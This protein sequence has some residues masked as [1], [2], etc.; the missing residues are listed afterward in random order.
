MG[1]LPWSFGFAIIVSILGWLQFRSMFDQTVVLQAAFESC[2]TR[3]YDMMHDIEQ[4]A[5]STY[6]E[7]VPDS[8]EPPAEDDEEHKRPPRLSRLVHIGA[9]FS[10]TSNAQKE[11][12]EK[13]FRNLLQVLYGTQSLPDG[14]D[15]E[16]IF[17]H[18]RTQALAMEQK[19]PIKKA[20]YLANIELE[21]GDLQHSLYRILKGGGTSPTDYADSLLSYISTTQ[22]NYCANAYLAP[23][24]VLLALFEQED[25]VADIMEYRQELYRTLRKDKLAD[26]NAMEQEFRQRF[27]S[28]LPREINAEFI[29]FHVSKTRPPTGEYVYER[30]VEDNEKSE[31]TT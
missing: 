1:F 9:L 20:R 28:K 30:P 19:F 21:E 16:Q 14:Q 8:E 11:T 2:E 3:S 27:A 13:I 25:I 15:A 10:A 18:V 17:E 22:K 23:R 7:H 4:N 29:D 6:A 12:Q 5:Y 24:P 26:K 31:E